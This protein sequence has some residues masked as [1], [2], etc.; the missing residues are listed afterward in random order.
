M[1]K[2]WIFP[3]I[4]YNF[5]MMG[6]LLKTIF[7]WKKFGFIYMK[8]IIMTVGLGGLATLLLT[9]WNFFHLMWW[10]LGVM[11]EKLWG[12][13]WYGGIVGV[14]IAQKPGLLWAHMALLI[15]L[16][17]HFYTTFDRQSHKQPWTNKK[18]IQKLLDRLPIKLIK[19]HYKNNNFFGNISFKYEKASYPMGYL[20]YD[21]SLILKNFMVINGAQNIEVIQWNGGVFH[22]KYFKSKKL[23]TALFHWSYGVQLLLTSFIYF[24]VNGHKKL[25]YFPLKKIY[26]LFI[27]DKQKKHSIDYNN[28]YIFNEV[29]NPKNIVYIINQ[30]PQESIENHGKFLIK[31]LENCLVQSKINKKNLVVFMYH[32]L[33]NFNKNHGKIIAPL[34]AL[35]KSSIGYYNIIMVEDNS[36]SLVDFFYQGKG[37]FM[38]ANSALLLNGVDSMAHSFILM[39]SGGHEKSILTVLKLLHKTHGVL[40]PHHH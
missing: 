1:G 2:L 23:M 26:N 4:D 3:V 39:G 28:K 36:Q 35:I 34:A 12:N 9:Y 13:Q 38:D 27:I 20:F 7:Y 37:S 17:F 21:L 29:F 25:M 11:L 15:M 14:I 31:Y 32:Q 24:G 6:P 5:S 10:P 19:I 33:S 8:I 16:L 22:D 40:L 30:K 18:Q